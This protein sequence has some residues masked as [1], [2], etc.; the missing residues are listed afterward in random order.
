LS[1]T[2]EFV[3]TWEVR[4][5]NTQSGFTGFDDNIVS[6]YA[7][8]LSTREIQQHIE[9]IYHVEVSAGLISRVTDEVMDEVRTWAKPAAR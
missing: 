9:E 4:L 2:N 7:R 1:E 3:T 6:L 5:L 8:G